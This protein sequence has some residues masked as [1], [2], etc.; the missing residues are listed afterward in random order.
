MRYE[1]DAG[2]SVKCV[3]HIHPGNESEPGVVYAGVDPAGLFRSE[4]SG[5]TWSEVKGLNRHETRNRWMPGKGG[6]ILHSIVPDAHDAR[7]MH[8]AISAA[9]V[10]YTEDGGATWQSRNRGTRADFLP[11]KYPDLGQCV[12]KLLSARRRQS[13]LP[14]ESLRRVSQRFLGRTLEGHLER[15]ALA[16]RI[17]HGRSSA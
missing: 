15:P 9:G 8:I 13:P 4:D 6:M 2:L 12:H 10:F 11:V 7:K 16:I 17:L 1:P 5:V 14:A 3:W